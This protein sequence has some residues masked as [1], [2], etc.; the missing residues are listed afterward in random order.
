MTLNWGTLE[1]S[2]IIQL[3]GLEG[4]EQITHI[5]VGPDAVPCD[6]GFPWYGLELGNLKIGSVT[7]NNVNDALFMEAG[8]SYLLVHTDAF[9]NG[10]IRGQILQSSGGGMSQQ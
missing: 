3:F 1:V 9:S 5:H 6:F 2:Y 8:L 7:L 10:E 4:P